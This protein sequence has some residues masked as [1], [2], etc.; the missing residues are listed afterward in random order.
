MNV[1]DE[2]DFPPEYHA[3]NEDDEDANEEGKQLQLEVQAP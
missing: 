2:E 1:V 3:Q